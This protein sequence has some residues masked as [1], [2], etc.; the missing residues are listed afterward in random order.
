MKRLSAVFLIVCLC[1][2]LVSPALADGFSQDADAIERAAASVVKLY[3]YDSY[4]REIATGS[5]FVAVDDQTVFTN[6]HVI[7]NGKRIVAV[8][9]DGKQYEIGSVLCKNKKLDVAVLAFSK[10]SGLTPLPLN[11]EKEMKRGAKVV[12]IG[13][14]IGI[15]NVVSIGNISAVYDENGV[16]WIQFTAPISNGSSGGALLNDAG[17]V[18][19]ITSASYKEGQNLNL[20]VR[21]SAAMQVYSGRNGTAT[22]L[23]EGQAPSLPGGSG[24]DEPEAVRT[25]VIN[26]SSK[27][28]HLPTCKTVEKMKEENKAYF[29]GTREELIDAGY[30]PCGLCHP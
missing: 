9:D 14:P 26:S 30:A 20:A 11:A 16:P 13:S 7:E 24:A 3:I 27:R 2:A 10:P 29:N 4:G 8:S 28:F 22:A 18:I 15:R 5:G 12:A 19:G 21:I 1:A 6:H 23:N 25:Y 17:E